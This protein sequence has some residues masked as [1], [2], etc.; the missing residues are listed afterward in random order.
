MDSLCN[1]II[2]VNT[3]ELFPSI[4]CNLLFFFYEGGGRTKKKSIHIFCKGEIGCFFQPS[5]FPMF[6]GIKAIIRKVALILQRHLH[7]FNNNGTREVPVK[8]T[9]LLTKPE[10][11]LYVSE[12]D[13]IHC[14]HAVVCDTLTWA[15]LPQLQ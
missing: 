10:S 2:K 1:S 6:S 9:K 3:R 8:S 7:I 11:R 14:C 12:C 15:T 4:C 13:Q 5:G